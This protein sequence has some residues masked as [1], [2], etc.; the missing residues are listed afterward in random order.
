MLRLFSFVWLCSAYD[1]RACIR[2]CQMT[3]DNFIIQ[4]KRPYCSCWRSVMHF[5]HSLSLSFCY[6]FFP[7][8]SSAS[9]ASA[10]LAIFCHFIIIEMRENIFGPAGLGIYFYWV[11]KTCAIEGHPIS[12][13]W[14]RWYHFNALKFHH[15]RNRCSSDARQWRRCY[16]YRL[17]FQFIF[18]E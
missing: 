3:Q 7:F 11:C 6:V 5:F 14:V 9:S 10:S 13:V 12:V 2:F 8:S 16:A 17:I 4:K 18:N 1:L 15:Q